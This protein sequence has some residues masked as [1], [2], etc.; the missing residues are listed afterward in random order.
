MVEVRL[1]AVRPDSF[2]LIFRIVLMF[3]FVASL[4]CFICCRDGLV[5][6][7]QVEDEHFEEILLRV[8]CG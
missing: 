3:F 1:A 7:C 8:L 6:S 5:I 2:W 4:D